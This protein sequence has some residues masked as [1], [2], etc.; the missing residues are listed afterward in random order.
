MNSDLLVVGAVLNT[1]SSQ[2]DGPGF[3]SCSIC[4]GSLTESMP[5]MKPAMICDDR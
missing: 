5:V 1:V 4:S 3:E 2:H